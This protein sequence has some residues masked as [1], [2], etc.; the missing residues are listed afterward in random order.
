MSP[1]LA[2]WYGSEAP[3]VLRHSAETNAVDRLDAA[4]PVLTGEIAYAVRRLGRRLS[5]AIFAGHP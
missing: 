1:R 4:A 2:S 3:D 5:D